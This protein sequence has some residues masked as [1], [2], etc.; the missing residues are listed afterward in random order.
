[1]NQKELNEIRRRWKPERSAVSVIYGCYVNSAREIVSQFDTPFGLLSHD[2]GEMYLALM[3]KV[4]SGTLGKNLIDIEFAT[5]QVAGSEEHSLLMKLKK[6]LGRDEEARK[7]LFEKIINALSFEET[8]GYLILLAGESYDVPVYGRDGAE[9]DDAGE[10]F[11][12]FLCAV[13]PVRSASPELGYSA[14][15]GEFH[16][17]TVGQTVTA[18]A[19]GFMFPC[20]DSRATNI[21]NALYYARKPAEL[22]Q[23]LIDALFCTPPVMSAP[24]QKDAFGAAI[25][26]ALDAQCSYDIVQAVHEHICARIAEH[27]EAKDPDKLELSVGEVGAMLR[28]SGV[29]DDAV[30][31]FRAECEKEFGENA[32]LNPN[33]I[34]DAKKFK[35]ET[36]E[37]KISVSPENS[38]LIETRIID[39]RKYLLIPADSGVEVNGISVSIK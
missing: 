32:A 26:G 20:F 2:E 30:E 22:H 11:K 27:K 14:D 29:D 39:G 18:P 7:A 35:V 38:Y 9:R 24:E 10:V 12:Y 25:T 3:K 16:L 36:P 4:L 13:C 37:I 31:S 15:S 21:Y 6:E 34:I 28:E 1:M 19:L 23:E 33:N 5:A 8:S 17:N